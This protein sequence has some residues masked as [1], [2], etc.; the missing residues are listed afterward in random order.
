VKGG[1]GVRRVISVLHVGLAWV[2]LIAVLAEFFFAGLG[3]FHASDFQIHMMT[4]Y[5]IGFASVLMLIVALA[6]WLGR[7]RI[8]LSAWLIVLMFIQMWLVHSTPVLA[9]LHPVNAVVILFVVFKLVQIGPFIRTRSV[10]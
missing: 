3:V 9:A 4:G 6:G 5:T 2:L 10:Q 8:L 1:N 7:T